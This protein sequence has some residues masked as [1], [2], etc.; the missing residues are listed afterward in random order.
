M[1]VSCF[2]KSAI[3]VQ[4]WAEAGH[5]CYCVDIAHEPGERREGNIVYVGADIMDWLP[6]RGIVDIAFF[7]PPCTDVAVS[8]ARW[9][10]KKGLKAL[11][12]ALQLFERSIV[13]AEWFG[14]PYMIENPVSTVSTYYRRPDYTFHPWEYGDTYMKKT[15]LWTGGGFRM[16]EP[17][18]TE[19][20]EGVDERIHRMAPSPDRAEKRS[21]TPPGFA[22]A[23]YEA[24]KEPQP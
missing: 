19:R 8:G 6:P 17:Q 4:P 20:P 12:G 3:M 10:R 5:L 18:Y 23:V 24:N 7:F 13:L 11:V 2:D 16:P 14:C 21:L 15:C 1:I 22:K 9:F